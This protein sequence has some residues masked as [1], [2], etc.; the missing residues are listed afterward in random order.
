M[1]TNYLERG[2][3]SGPIA[4]MLTSLLWLPIAGCGGQ[5]SANVPPPVDDTHGGTVSTAA[6]G[7][8]A[9]VEKKKGLNNAQKAGVVLVGAAALYYLYRQHQKKAA[10]GQNG[11]YYLSK[12]GRVYYR[13][14]QHRAHY[15]TPP[16]GGVRVPEDQAQQY[17]DFKGYNGDTSRGRD[18]SGLGTAQ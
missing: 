5:K 16:A 2:K 13:D 12:N 18:L 14:A 10:E 1:K 4:I 17:R 11:K 6:S 3:G 8:A 9:P 15:V 7:A